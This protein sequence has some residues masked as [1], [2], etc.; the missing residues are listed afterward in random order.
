M[1]SDYR[2]MKQ[3]YGVDRMLQKVQQELDTNVPVLEGTDVEA[4]S[5]A[6]TTL[7][8]AGSA[9]LA[10]DLRSQAGQEVGRPAAAAATAGAGEE[11]GAGGPVPPVR[12]CG[13]AHGAEARGE[14]WASHGGHHRTAE[15][16]GDQWSKRF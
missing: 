11:A 13:G 1:I 4:G 3:H 12:R 7:S 6:G 8:L 15:G 9:G 5:L 10:Q 2:S 14:A 16:Q